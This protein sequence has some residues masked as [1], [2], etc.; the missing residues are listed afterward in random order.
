MTEPLADKVAIVTGAAHPDGIGAAI[1][2]AYAAAG[3]RVVVADLP[4][5]EGFEH[6]R[7]LPCDVSDR[8]A[9]DALMDACL[10]QHDRVDILVNNAGVGFGTA[11]FLACSKEDF[12]AC[13]AVN[14]GGIVNTC[15]AIIPHMRS[16]GGG[17]I[18][19]IASLAGLG[20]VDGM[21]ASYT[22]SKFAAVG[23]TK[24]IAAQFAAEGIRC[25]AICPGAVATRMQAEAHELLATEHDITVEAAAALELSAIPMGRTAQPREI[26][27]AAVFLASEAARYV[28]GVALPVAGGMAPGL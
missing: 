28:T 11:D 12:D 21:P 17:A 7:A 8:D 14:V 2:N 22:A 23:L 13:L 1:A 18:I 27:E 5:V 26:A 6:A 24:Q 4:S 15:Q 10:A 20:A 16:Q 9:V 25:N 19:N 3:A